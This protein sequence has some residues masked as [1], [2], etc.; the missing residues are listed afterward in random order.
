VLLLLPRVGIA[1]WFSD[2][3]FRQRPVFEPCQSITDQVSF[4]HKTADKIIVLCNRRDWYF[5]Y[6]PFCQTKRPTIFRRMDVSLSS[7]GKGI[8]RI[9]ES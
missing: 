4:P 1:M 8:E 3:H 7:G 9:S 2:T 6:C 5:W